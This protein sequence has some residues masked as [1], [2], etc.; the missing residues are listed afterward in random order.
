MA[1][2]VVQQ[3]VVIKVTES[4]W[5]LI[6]KC[7]AMM[8]GVENLRNIPEEKEKAAALN[9]QLLGQ[10][11]YVLRGQL[12]SAEDALANTENEDSQ[13]DSLPARMAEAVNRVSA[14]GSQ[15][16]EKIDVGRKIGD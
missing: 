15:G 8:A 2:V 14:V 5:K 10:R 16:P 6:M 7:L 1:E 4:E 3:N 9:K 12:K 13:E 11:V